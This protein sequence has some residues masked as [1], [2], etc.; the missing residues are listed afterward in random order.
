[1]TTDEPP[2][3]IILTSRS[4]QQ[5]THTIGP[6]CTKPLAGAVAALVTGSPAEVR[7]CRPNVCIAALGR[8]HEG[9]L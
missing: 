9:S 4:G 7:Q 3:Y 2:Y 6:F 8:R 5:Q 1:M